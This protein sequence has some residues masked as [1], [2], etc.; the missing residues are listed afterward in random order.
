MRPRIRANRQLDDSE[1]QDVQDRVDVETGIRPFAAGEDDRRFEHRR[2][3]NEADHIVGERFDETT[4][5]RL[6]EHDRQKR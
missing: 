1:G 5:L 2:S 4:S 6:V 3:R